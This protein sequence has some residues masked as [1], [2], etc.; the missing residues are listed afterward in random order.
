MC[1]FSS[2]ALTDDRYLAVFTGLRPIGLVP[3][4]NSQAFTS[5]MTF[6]ARSQD[7][8]FP[9]IQDLRGDP[10]T[11]SAIMTCIQQQKSNM[12]GGKPWWE[13]HCQSP[14]I[15]SNHLTADFYGAQTDLAS[16]YKI[17]EGIEPVN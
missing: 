12:V 4:W 2:A 14:P 3:F 1:V 5:S 11:G 17:I 8:P 13:V 15:M 10:R 16:F 9:L 6:A 7:M